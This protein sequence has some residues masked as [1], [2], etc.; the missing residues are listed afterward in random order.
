MLA[1]WVLV[2]LFLSAGS[3]YLGRRWGSAAPIAVFATLTVIA[4][5]TA[6]KIVNFWIFSAPA[7]VIV[8]A[9]TFL[10]TDIIS[11]V[12]GRQEATKAVW[13]GFY[14]N[15]ILFFYISA[16]VRWEA[17]PFAED[18]ARMFREVLG[19]VPRIVVASMIAYLVSQHHDVLA[20]HIWKH[21][22]GGRF[23]WLRNNA[24]TLVSQAI[25]TSLFITIA[26]WGKFPGT[27]MLNL[28]IGQYLVKMTIAVLDTP[29]CYLFSYLARSSPGAGRRTTSLRRTEA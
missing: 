1:L 13:M 19:L 11:E 17:A 28:L 21:K 3:A 9:A 26:F 8:Y 22:T 25:D 12:W 20:F 4:N 7:A 6:G 16:A 18:Y 5:V 10:L 15:L 27:Q 23:L 29:F 2:T 24:S 14:A